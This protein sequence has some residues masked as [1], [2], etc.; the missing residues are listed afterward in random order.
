[1][2]ED[3]YMVEVT[4]NNFTVEVLEPSKNELLISGDSPAEVSPA[5]DTVVLLDITVPAA[6]IVEVQES[7]QIV[8]VSGQTVNVVEPAAVGRQ[9]DKGDQGD[10]GEQGEQGEPGSGVEDGEIHLTPKTSSSGPE[11]TVFYDSSD[12]HLFVG[13]E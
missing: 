9:G 6:N 2:S 13:T 5:V 3:R 7:T 8:E 4:E 1:M 12:N 10:Q 11:G